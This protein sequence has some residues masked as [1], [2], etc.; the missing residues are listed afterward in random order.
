MTPVWVRELADDFWDRAGPPEAFP[1]TFRRASRAF[2]L[3]EVALPGLT[4]FAA[5]DWLG[6]R[7]IRVRVPDRDRPLRGCLVSQFGAGIVFVD[8]A[9]DPAEGRFTRA[10]ELAHFLR[11][12]WQ[13]RRRVAAKLGAGALAVLDGRRGPTPGER[14]GALL[15]HVPAGPLIHLLGRGPDETPEGR[16]AEAAADR[17]AFEL[18]APAAEVGSRAELVERFGLPPGKADEYA[19]LLWPRVQKSRLLDTLR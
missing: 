17:L 18:L 8:A 13:V 19:A 16:A 2:P 7:A 1:R 10:H 3:T 12:V 4:L 11:D 14:L 5:R 6:R 9:D 15:T